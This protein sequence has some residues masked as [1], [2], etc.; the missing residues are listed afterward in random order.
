MARA[1][2]ATRKKRQPLVQ[3]VCQACGKAFMAKPSNIAAGGGKACSKACSY[4]VRKTRSDKKP[5]KSYVCQWCGKVFIDKHAER[6][7]Q[8]CSNKCLGLSKRRDRTKHPR[9]KHAAELQAWAREVIL[10]DKVCVRCGVS[11]KLQAHHVKSYARHPALRLDVGNGVALC[12]V[13]HHAHHPKHKLE[14]FLSRGGQQV[15]RCVVCEAPFVPR[16]P[17]QRSCSISCGAKAR[18]QHRVY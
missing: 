9:S 7:R 6:P 14:W 1:Y 2:P 13:C 12:P 5:R 15:Q 17:T 11:E 16:K 4:K 8:Y 3:R 18:Q 10:R